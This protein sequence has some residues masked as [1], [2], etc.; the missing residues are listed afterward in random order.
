[1]S[2]FYTYIYYDPSRNNEPIY[3]GKG[4]K[5]RAWLHIKRKNKHPFVQRLQFMKKNG[6]IPIIG[7][8]AGLD[9]EFAHLLEMEL[10]AKFGRKDLGKGPLLN[11]TDGGEGT[12]NVSL[13]IRNHLSEIKRGVT[14]SGEH[15]ISISIG[16]TGRQVTQETRDKIS[17]SNK[18]KV[19]SEESKSKMSLAAK[20]RVPWNKGKKGCQ[21]PWNKGISTGPQS[22]EIIEKKASSRRGKTWSISRREAQDR[23]K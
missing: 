3:V 10:I 19:M 22:P 7:I 9:E 8:Y 15:R 6:I 12:T 16:N 21:T 5:S 23:R 18:G 17:Y 13:D 14:L 20:N 1:M 2:N 4:T 11:L